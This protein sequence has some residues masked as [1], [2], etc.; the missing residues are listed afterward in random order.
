M[1]AAQPLHCQRGHSVTH[2][3]QPLKPPVAFTWLATSSLTLAAQ[4]SLLASASHSPCPLSFPVA[5]NSH[6]RRPKSPSITG[7]SGVWLGRV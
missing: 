2:D 5:G 6:N 4:P 3:Y 1:E 7:G